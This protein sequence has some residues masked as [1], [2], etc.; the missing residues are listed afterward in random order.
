MEVELRYVRGD[1]AVYLR[2]GS[3]RGPVTVRIADRGYGGGEKR[4][5]LRAGQSR[6]VGFGLRGSSGWYDLAV[7]VEG[8]GR[9][10]RRFAG[11]VED[12]K[13]G[14]SDPVMGRTG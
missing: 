5:R 11:R 1:A 10:G 3:S 2:N 9:Y 14:V 7:S 12:G 4:V 8:A 6:T 13:E